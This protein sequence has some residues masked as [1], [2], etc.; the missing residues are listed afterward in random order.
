MH[1]SI[2]STETKNGSADSEN[3]ALSNCHRTGK[4]N[5]KKPA[6]EKAET[7]PDQDSSNSKY[8]VEDDK[9]ERKDGPGGD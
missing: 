1:K 6:S 4:R 8:L 3:N 7:A 9:R 5:I 2:F